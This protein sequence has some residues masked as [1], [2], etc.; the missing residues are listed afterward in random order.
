MSFDI[1]ELKINLFTNIKDASLRTIELTKSILYHPEMEGITEV[2]N[3][4]PYFTFDV[5]YPLNRLRYLTYKDRVEFLFNKEKFR[6][7]LEA[8]SKDKNTLRKGQVKSQAD[9]QQ[10]YKQRDR[11]IEKNVMVMLE[12]L[13]PTKFPVINDIQTSYDIVFD[14]SKFKRMVI[15]PIITQY[16]SYL[17]M[18]EQIYTFKKVI[19]M[20]DILNHPKYQRM[21]SEYRKLVDWSEDEKF[22][23]MKVANRSFTEIRKKVLELYNN[24]IKPEV[25]ANLPNK[26]TILELII[27]SD[28]DVDNRVLL[29]FLLQDLLSNIK[30]RAG[31]SPAGKYK[32]IG[33][34]LEILQK[35][36]TDMTKTL[37]TDANID[38]FLNAVKRHSQIV[39]MFEKSYAE[40]STNFD[41]NPPAEYRNFAYAVLGDYK[42]PMRES[43]NY[44]LQELINGEDNMSVAD[45]FKFMNYIYK[46]YLYVIGRERT[47]EY[48]SK[49]MNVGL[50]YINTNTT[51]GVRREIYVYSD[52]IKGEVNKDNAGKIF[53][54]FVGDHLGNEFEFLVRM[55]MYG[56]TGSKDTRRWNIDRNRMIF[57]IKNASSDDS[58]SAEKPL[59]LE[60]K[61]L[62]SKGTGNL[63][64]P[65]KTNLDRLPSYFASEI[66][67]KDKNISEAL[68]KANRYIGSTQIYEQDLLNYIK[69]NESELY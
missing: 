9:E 41:E 53:C 54:P 1:E 67:G 26:E 10:Y 39:S 47:S 4:H 7:R 12:V 3:E 21:L 62:D 61:P 58:K 11:N 13:F 45:F 5:K 38:K 42:K 59:E 30:M 23:Q 24:I 17:K 48:Y 25:D 33:E 60:A 34:L 37:V 64:I 8:Y 63:I 66:I 57:T 55:E 36:G 31:D 46:K 43:T 51:G 20:N 35:K 15:N 14:K 19:W 52:F 29:K 50:S 68:T 49:L 65:S 32:R 16:Y 44:E 56:K 40:V 2:L 28:I 6:E 69:N 18:G 27:L 22:R